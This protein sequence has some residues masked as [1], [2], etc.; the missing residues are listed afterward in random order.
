MGS[1]PPG[2]HADSVDAL[3]SANY[4]TRSSYSPEVPEISGPLV[5]FDRTVSATL[6]PALVA[7]G[8]LDWLLRQKLRETGRA[9]VR[10]LTG[11]HDAGFAAALPLG[12]FVKPSV[13]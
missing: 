2:V 3:R 11:Q 9:G 5:T 8:Q 7:G 13:E 1:R 6:E 12:M 10:E 4:V